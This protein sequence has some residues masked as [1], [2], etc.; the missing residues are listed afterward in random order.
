MQL[1]RALNALVRRLSLEARYKFDLCIC[2]KSGKS[3]H[4]FAPVR[5]LQ[6]LLWFIYPFELLELVQWMYN[7]VDIN[8]LTVYKTSKISTLSLLVFVLLLVLS[9]LSGY[10]D[11][12]VTKT[13]PYN[14]LWELEEVNININIIEEIYF[15]VAMFALHFESDFANICSLEAVNVGCRLKYRQRHSIH[16]ISLLMSRLPTLSTFGH[17]FLGI[18]NKDF[19]HK[20]YFMEENCGLALSDASACCFVLSELNFEKQHHSHFGNAPSLYSRILLN[21]FPPGGALIFHRL[22]RIFQSCRWYSPR[23]SVHVLQYHF[24]FSGVPMKM[25]NRIHSLPKEVDG[26]VK[27]VPLEMGSNLDLSRMRFINNMPMN[28]PL[29]NNSSAKGKSIDS[30]TQ[31]KY[32][33]VFILNICPFLEQ[34]IRSALYIGLRILQLHHRSVVS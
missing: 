24:A 31:Y 19:P 3:P 17:L 14:L 34:L 22:P 10:L 21:G 25:K 9:K 30:S 20:G 11:H 1:V 26:D 8:Y 27:G 15:K 13:V 5:A 18:L 23:K 28:F 2:T 12:L 16:P 6:A 32:L 29:V 33:E 4:R 7:R